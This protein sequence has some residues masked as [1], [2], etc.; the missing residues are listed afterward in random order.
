MSLRLL[1]SL[2]PPGLKVHRRGID[3][4]IITVDIAFSAHDT[5]LSGITY[6]KV[7]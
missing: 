1:D 7:K 4:V 6:L 2:H 5:Y 3:P